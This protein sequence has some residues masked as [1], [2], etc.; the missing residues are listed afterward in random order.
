MNSF[1]KQ[2]CFHIQ[3]NSYWVDTALKAY[4]DHFTATTGKKKQKKLENKW[5]E[6]DAQKKKICATNHFNVPFVTHHRGITEIGIPL[7]ILCSR[8]CSLPETDHHCKWFNQLIIIINLCTHYWDKHQIK[9]DGFEKIIYT[10]II[11]PSLII[12]YT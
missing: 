4:Q 7:Q 12:L 9:E 2:T 8:D 5:R 1:K 3:L 11:P 10:N 6:R